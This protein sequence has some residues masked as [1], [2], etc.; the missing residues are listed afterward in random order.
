MQREENR[1]NRETDRET[2]KQRK[3]RN[4]QSLFIFNFAHESYNLYATIHT[5]FDI[6][7]HPRIHCKMN[8]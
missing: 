7:N 5:L 2:E 3:Q 1:G 8:A 6:F 4:N